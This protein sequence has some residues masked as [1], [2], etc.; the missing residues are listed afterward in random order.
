[1]LLALIEP[2]A[3]EVCDTPKAAENAA[4]TASLLAEGGET[5]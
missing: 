3:A 1:M 5:V 2:A 4:S